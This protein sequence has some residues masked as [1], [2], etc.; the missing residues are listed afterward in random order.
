MLLLA[1][2]LL[3]NLNRSTHANDID[4]IMSNYAVVALFFDATYNARMNQIKDDTRKTGKP[5]RQRPARKDKPDWL[6][7]IKPSRQRDRKR[8]D[9]HN[10]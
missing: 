2:D 9:K 3:P 10:G 7:G 1:V 4:H 5:T 6:A 8:K